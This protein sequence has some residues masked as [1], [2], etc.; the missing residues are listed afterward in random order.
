MVPCL[1]SDYIQKL[2]SEKENDFSIDV[3][4]IEEEEEEEE[5]EEDYQMEN[6][7]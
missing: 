4:E 7:L 1:T 6:H 3:L 2:Y 5:E